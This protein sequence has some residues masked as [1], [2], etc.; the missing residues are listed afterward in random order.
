MDGRRTLQ[1]IWDQASERLGDDAPTQDEVIGLVSE[2]YAADALVFDVAPDLSESY[3]RS[4]RQSRRKAIERAM[5][6]F[7]WRVP[8]CDPDR[9]LTCLLPFARLLIGWPAALVWGLVVASGLLFAAMHWPELS[10]NLMDQAFAP[11]NVFFVWLLF[12]ALKLCHELAHALTT[13]VFG[14]E[15][16]EL[17]VMFLVFTPVPY[18]D[19]SA[20]WEFPNKWHRILVGAAG[21]MVELYLASLALFVWLSAEPGV[22]R[23][24]AY[25]A[26]LI[27]GVSTVLFNANPLLRFDGYFM[28]MDFLEIPNLKSRAGRYFAYLAERY[29]FGQQDAE[30][31]Q[32]TRGERL[33]FLLYGTASSLFRVIVVAGIL[34]FLGEEFPAIAVLFAGFVVVA[35]VVVPLIKGLS[36]LLTS[37][38]LRRVRVRAV[39]TTACFATVTA[40]ML[41]FIP[42]PLYTL[43]EGVVWLPEEAYVRAGTNGFVERVVAE[44]GSRVQPGDLL[45]LCKNPTLSSQLALLEARLQELNA[46]RTEQQP[47]DRVKT[48]MLDEEILYTKKERDRVREQVDQLKIQS[49][50]AGIFVTPTAEDLPGRFLRQGDALAY[51]IDLRT[52]IVRALIGQDE[53]DLVRNKLDSV[54]VRLAE[55]VTSVLL[56]DVSRV[57]PAATNQLPSPVLGDAGGGQVAMD[58]SD[59]KGTTSLQRYFQVDLTLDH[60][61]RVLDA[62]GRA[63]VRFNHGW[64]PLFEQWSRRMRQLFLSRFNV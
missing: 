13:K 49:K 37:P 4:V 50:R 7:S 3:R 16:H 39:L 30:L 59:P 18:V 61:T 52:T 42:I 6:A 21:M 11:Q 45:I 35:M 51:V 53:I 57:V 55:R 32:A 34:L 27:A 44:P 31:P 20:A 63:Y 8:L 25:N 12:P 26:I 58:Q 24:A 36:F 22:V 23:T 10:H 33:W 47:T 48:A 54:Q 64:S 2:L 28:F 1:Q 19:A 29:V 43:T 9:L 15:V 5:Q 56:A 40:G 38:R 17:G 14:G 41:G 60:A 46:R 62:G